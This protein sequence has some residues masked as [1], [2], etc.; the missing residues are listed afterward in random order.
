M[1]RGFNLPS[2]EKKNSQ[3]EPIDDAKTLRVVRGVVNLWL[4]DFGSMNSDDMRRE[5]NRLDIKL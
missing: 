2:I 4:K 5:Y 1:S 3:S